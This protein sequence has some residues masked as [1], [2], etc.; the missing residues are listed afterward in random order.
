MKYSIKKE[1]TY[2]TISFAFHGELLATL[3]LHRSV[4]EK[5]IRS[6]QLQQFFGQNK[7][8]HRFYFDG[9]LVENKDPELIDEW[10]KEIDFSKEKDISPED[11]A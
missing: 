2:V 9:V 5:P 7:T 1:G 6:I 11:F 4:A 10:V 3:T 8:G